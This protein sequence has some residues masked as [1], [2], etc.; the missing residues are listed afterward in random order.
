[1][2][3]CLLYQPRL[4]NFS[5]QKSSLL[6]L[7]ILLVT[8]NLLSRTVAMMQILHS[9]VQLS[10]WLVLEDWDGDWWRSDAAAA[11]D[12]LQAAYKYKD[13]YNW[14][15]TYTKTKKH[16]IGQR[17]RRIQRQRLMLQPSPRLQRKAGTN[18]AV[19]LIKLTR[20]EETRVRGKETRR[21]ENLVF[22][23]SLPA[24]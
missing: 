16:T 9:S 17:Q 7:I 24:C 12:H 2:G 15:M 23:A 4:L 6:Y 11:P 21:F 19:G 5:H 8:S 14:T 1:M 22:L 3:H 20:K 18:E 13:T 10:G